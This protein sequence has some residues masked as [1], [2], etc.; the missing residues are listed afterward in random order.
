[1][2]QLKRIMLVGLAAATILSSG[3]SKKSNTSVFSLNSGAADIVQVAENMQKYCNRTDL[4]MGPA[5]PYDYI[6]IGFTSAGGPSLQADPNN[7]L[8]LAHAV[9]DFSSGVGIKRTE[10]PISIFYGPPVPTAINS[11]ASIGV[12]YQTECI[13]FSNDH[14]NESVSQVGNT[15]ILIKN[16]HYVFDSNELITLIEPLA[17]KTSG[18]FTYQFPDT[19]MKS[20]G[21]INDKITQS[22]GRVCELANI[23]AEG[24]TSATDKLMIWYDFANMKWMNVEL[25]DPYGSVEV[26]ISVFGHPGDYS[27][28]FYTHNIDLGSQSTD[29]SQ[30]VRGILGLPPW[31]KVSSP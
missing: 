20:D 16:C 12:D 24:A 6:Q 18:I 22:P 1:M 4:P 19:F 10:L 27:G 30:I 3:C 7:Y 28:S 9:N 17:E 31:N 23:L 8:K 21:T 2:N 25:G 5:L 13:G 15:D 14:P 29:Y 26:T 11:K